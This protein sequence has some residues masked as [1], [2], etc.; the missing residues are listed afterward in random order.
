MA[1]E[2]QRRGVGSMLLE[3]GCD[4]ADFHGWKSFVMASPDG[5]PLYTKFGFKAMGKV[6]TEYGG[7]TSMLRE[8]NLPKTGISLATLRE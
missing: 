8:P 6:W 4:K 7:F 5:V 2:H 1:P 3:W